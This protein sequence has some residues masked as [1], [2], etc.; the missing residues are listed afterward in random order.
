MLKTKRTRIVLVGVVIFSMLAIY[1]YMPEVS[2]ASLDKASVKLGD[3]DI[4]ATATSTVTV[5]WLQ[6]SVAGQY[7]RIDFTAGGFSGITA[8]NVV[9]PNGGMASTTGAIV[10]CT[11]ALDAV[12]DWEVEIQVTNPGTYGDKR[13]DI[14]THQAGGTE[15]EASDVR[16]YIISSVTMSATVLATLEFTL[17]GTQPAR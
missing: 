6:P 10:D 8:G 12:T 5:I 17:A 9:C 16:V 1:G 11:G 15:I 3:S 14:S 4:N 13:I 7:L 2:A